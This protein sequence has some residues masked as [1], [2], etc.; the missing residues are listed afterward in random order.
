MTTKK[1]S[2]SMGHT[3]AS[4]T[5]LTSLAALAALTSLAACT[6]AESAPEPSATEVE[7]DEAPPAVERDPAAPAVEPG[8]PMERDEP[9]APLAR[10]KV[11]LKIE[12]S[13]VNYDVFIAAGAPQDPVNAVVTIMP[14]VIVGSLEPGR[15]AFTTGQLPPGSKLVLRNRGSILGAGGAGGSGGN[16]GTGGSGRWPDQIFCGRNGDK[17]GAAIALTVPARINNRG[18]IFGGGGGGGGMSGCNQTAGGGGG[19]GAFGGAGGPGATSLSEADEIAFCGQDNG[20]RQGPAGAAGSVFG[21]GEGG[22]S[23]DEWFDGAGGSGGGFGLP[24]AHSRECIPH[25][26][27]EGGA[28]GAAIER[29]GNAV[30]GVAD[31]AYDSG[32]GNLR[33]AVR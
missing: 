1:F 21:G 32:Q 2:C 6:E 13:L 22:K 7:R 17:G 20:Y 10:R 12:S 25:G 30:E 27:G 5:S 18:L 16:G 8:D 29:Y 9:D 19:A 23:G 4:L 3:S 28:P 14:N 11:E 31:G 24:G 26:G 15:P 33:G